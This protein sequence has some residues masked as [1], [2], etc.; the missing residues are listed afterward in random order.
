M[1]SYFHCGYPVM[2][3]KG[4]NKFPKIVDVS[5]YSDHSHCFSIVDNE[6]QRRFDYSP[7]FRSSTIVSFDRLG[8]ITVKSLYPGRLVHIGYK[9]EIFLA[10]K[11]FYCFDNQNSFKCKQCGTNKAWTMVKTLVFIG[12]SKKFFYSYYAFNE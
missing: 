10:T 12:W 6:K 2:F 3:Y 8:T 5:F 1:D 7:V 4:N 11:E 9:N